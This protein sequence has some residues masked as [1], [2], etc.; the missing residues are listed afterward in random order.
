VCWKVGLQRAAAHEHWLYALC[1]I[2]W[3]L[4]G[5]SFLGPASKRRLIERV[6]EKV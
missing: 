2:A 3:R 5:H 1:A 4:N 6:R